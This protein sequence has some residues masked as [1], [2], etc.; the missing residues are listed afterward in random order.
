MH[1]SRSKEYI[2]GTAGAFGSLHPW[3]QGLYLLSSACIPMFFPHPYVLLS[4]V[5]GGAAYILRMEGRRA[6]RSLGGLFFLGCF[7]VLL[8]PFVNHG[9]QTVLLYINDRPITWEA[10]VYGGISALLFLE[11]L[12]WFFCWS[13]IITADRLLYLLGKSVPSFSL[14]IS[15][16][17]RLIP[18]YTRQAKAISQARRGVRM[19]S[20]SHSFL[21]KLRESGAVFSSLT[22]W[23]LENG[24]DTADSMRARGYGLPGRTFAFRY[25]RKTADWILGGLWCVCLLSFLAGIWAGDLRVFFFP[26]VSLPPWSM[27]MGLTLFPFSVL[28]FVPVLFDGW[29]GFRWKRLRSN[30]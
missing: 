27:W 13:K 10:I 15:M 26:V 18:R 17:L 21:R 20:D 30:L 8:N 14:L 5:C 6:L 24:V 23:A 22:T 4:A 7:L 12:I 28:C 29:E 11:V 19:D 25:G 3:I 2:R 1:S 16:A 9:G